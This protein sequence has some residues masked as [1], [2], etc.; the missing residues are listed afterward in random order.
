[1]DLV[2]GALTHNHDLL[3]LRHRDRRDRC[4]RRDRRA[5]G[6]VRRGGFRAALVVALGLLFTIVTAAPALAHA[7]LVS[8][9]PSDGAVIGSAPARVTLTFD[10]AVR[11]ETSE[12]KVLDPAGK[13]VSGAVTGNGPAVTIG[14]RPVTAQGTYTVSWRVIS[15]DSHPVAGAV[16]F[17]IGHPS[18]AATVTGAHAGAVVSGLFTVARF[19]AYLGFALLVGAVAFCCYAMPAAMDLRAVRLLIVA[20][21]AALVVGTFGSLTLQGPYAAAVGLSGLLR[22]EL[23]GQ[24]LGATYGKALAIRL[25]LLGMSPAL[26]AYGLSRLEA[27]GTRERWAFGGVGAVVA[28]GMAATWSVGGHAATSTQPAGT[29]PADMAHLCAM[30]VWLGGLATVV[31]VVRVRPD[32]EALARFSEVAAWCVT[33]LAGT[34]I[35]QAWLRV[36]T[37]SALLTTGYGVTLVV[38]VSVVCAILAIAFFSRRAVRAGAVQRAKRLGRL[39]AAEATGALVVLAVTAVLVE[40]QP[41]GQAFAARPATLRAH[42][43]T[44]GPNGAGTI[45]V[46]LPNRSRGLTEATVTVRDA[47]GKVRDVPE[48]DLAWTLPSHGIGPLVA[49]VNPVGGG[50]YQAVGSPLVAAGG[51]HLAVT[52][53]TDPIDEATVGLSVEIR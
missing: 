18:R 38:K 39:V 32:E 8:S 15:A 19:L 29:L 7:T 20:G 12:I 37:P 4:D 27:A 21:W 6:V 40:A 2:S 34:G 10:E 13:T 14:M 23:L 48:V 11:P 52:V 31:I 44:H 45:D 47:S 46:W 36:E 1:V 30:A 49:K 9:S 51:W 33:I 43:D 53:R 22:P 35:Y 26:L 17:S 25:V 3:R 28:I 42:Y 24:T 16:T 5:F 50:H 41:A